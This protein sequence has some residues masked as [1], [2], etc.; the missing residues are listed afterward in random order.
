MQGWALSNHAWRV[1]AL[2]I[3][4]MIADGYSTE[5]SPGGSIVD[6]LDDRVLSYRK[7]MRQPKHLDVILEQLTPLLGENYLI[8][9][10]PAENVVKVDLVV[11]QPNADR[12][13]WTMVTAGMS[14]EPMAFPSTLSTV[15]RMSVER[16][17][18]TIS[19]LPDAFSADP[20]GMVSDDQFRAGSS[21]WVVAL[22]AVL[23]HLPHDYGTWISA[24][25]S[26]P[27]G[28][29]AEPYA[30]HVPFSGVVLAPPN[31]WPERYHTITSSDGPINI[32]SVVPVY[33]NE[34][35]F[36]LSH[37]P[38]A[39]LSELEAFGF[40]EIVS[41]TRPDIGKILSLIMK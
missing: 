29:P 36:L 7:S 26:V 8:H 39:L 1:L 24:G 4:M 14:D 38:E 40:T 9:S 35:Q 25:S 21:A 17:E 32:L 18:L 11:F 2:G 23:A 16:G 34:M 20:A 10:L 37:G 27:N 6:R 3:G 41:G 31:H 12:P 15:E 22:M 19:L 28:D 13:Y 5:L 30:S 33:D